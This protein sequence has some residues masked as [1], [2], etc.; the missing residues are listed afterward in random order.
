MGYFNAFFKTQK[1]SN[2][3]NKAKLI[4]SLGQIKQVQLPI[5]VAELMLEN[6]GFATASVEELRKS[7][8]IT[9][10]RADDL[11]IGRKVYLLVPVEKVNSKLFDFQ[12]DAIEALTFSSSNGKMSRKLSGKSKVSPMLRNDESLGDLVKDLGR[13]KSMCEN[14]QKKRFSKGWEPILEPIL[15]GC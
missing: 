2:S 12:M 4:D 8:R 3:K 9:A 10:M 11:L 1:S 7:H 6:P 13:N 14:G 5:T 15:E